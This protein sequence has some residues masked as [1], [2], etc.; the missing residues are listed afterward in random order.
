MRPAGMRRKA[1]ATAIITTAMAG[2]LGLGAGILAVVLGAIGIDLLFL[3][4]EFQLTVSD[5]KEIVSLVL[6]LSV[7]VVVAEL[8]MRMRDQREFAIN[9]EKRV[10][11]LLDLSRRLAGAATSDDA[12]A[13]LAALAA[14]VTCG[15]AEVVLAEP[16]GALRTAG[17]A[18]LVSHGAADSGVMRWCHEFGQPAGRGMAT[19]PGVG[20]TCL[21][22]REAGH[23]LGVLVIGCDPPRDLAR[24]ELEL[25]TSASRQAAT[26]LAMLG[27]PWSSDPTRKRLPGTRIDT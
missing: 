20:I 12:A 22:I 27:E 13:A 23:G 15:N 17:R 18:G 25:L 16:A 19:L 2:A 6:M 3:H 1:A 5:S 7:G 8:I 10:G 21:P 24:E 26:R 11:R 4:P 9:A 14:D